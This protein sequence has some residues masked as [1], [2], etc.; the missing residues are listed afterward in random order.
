MT[1]AFLKNWFSLG[2]L[3]TY[4]LR[5]PVGKNIFELRFPYHSGGHLGVVVL[6]RGLRI[7]LPLMSGGGA[8]KR[9]KTNSEHFLDK[10]QV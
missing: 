5:C 8:L 6:L 2:R 4:G 1:F 10:I 7:L 9:D 3:G